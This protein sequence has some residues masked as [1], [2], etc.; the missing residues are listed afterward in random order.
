MTA[1][2][3]LMEKLTRMSMICRS[4]SCT[5]T[6]LCMGVKRSRA[7]AETPY[8]SRVDLVRVSHMFFCGHHSA[9]SDQSIAMSATERDAFT[10]VVEFWLMKIAEG[11]CDQRKTQKKHD[12]KRAKFQIEPICWNDHMEVDKFITLWI[13]TRLKKTDACQS[14]HKVGQESGWEKRTIVNKH[15]ARRTPHELSGNVQTAVCRIFLLQWF[16]RSRLLQF[17]FSQHDSTMY[18]TIQTQQLV[19]QAIAHKAGLTCTQLQDICFY[20]KIR[21][22]KTIVFKLKWL[23]MVLALPWIYTTFPSMCT[24][25][26]N[27]ELACYLTFQSPFTH[28]IQPSQTCAESL[29][30][31]F[32]CF[33]L[34]FSL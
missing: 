19:L 13:K 31:D 17:G 27:M 12:E 8:W 1:L 20:S 24:K 22:D 15:F 30:F 7:S 33:W 28:N 29:C 11:N 5:C 34:S 6:F 9:W 2:K 32:P 26:N 18:G 25:E 21:G 14:G 4:G 23:C 10:S 16:K 3:T